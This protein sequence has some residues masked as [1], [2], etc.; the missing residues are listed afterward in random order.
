MN[1]VKKI[2]PSICHKDMDLH[3]ETTIQRTESLI[4]VLQKSKLLS[5]FQE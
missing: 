2:Q 3:L 5:C 4:F 1:E